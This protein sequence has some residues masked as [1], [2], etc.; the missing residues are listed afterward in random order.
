MLAVRLPLRLWPGGTG[1][2]L[3]LG[4]LLLMGA[5]VVAG[6]GLRAALAF[7]AVLIH[8]LGHVVAARRLGIATYDVV[9]M[10]FG[11]VAHLD[12][13]ELVDPAAE[14]R[15]AV[16]GPAVSLALGGALWAAS[17][18]LPAAVAGASPSAGGPLWDAMAR[19][20]ERWGRDHVGLGLFNLLPAFPLDG[21][22]LARAALARR[23]GFRQATR[24]VGRVGEVSGAVMA[25]AAAAWYAY[26]GQGL[27][28]MV[29]GLFLLYAARMERHRAAGTWIRYLE[30]RLARDGRE[31]WP[32]TEGRV[33]VARQETAVK[34]VALRLIPGRFH[35]V[36]VVD[37][38]GRVVGLTGEREVVEAL[39][40]RGV[41][42][43]LSGVPYRKV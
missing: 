15:V 24:L 2:R 36:V 41:R 20:L 39:I 13:P 16:A 34:E 32:V 4:F 12:E 3:H 42:T 33:L 7:S 43:P 6:Q 22:R 38:G 10:P 9:L 17:V 37:S 28:A 23:A 31:R 25:G 5:M 14:M 26:A 40:E 18:A 27:G 8:E 30:R 35:L 21:G 11:G 1:L 19:V 29:M